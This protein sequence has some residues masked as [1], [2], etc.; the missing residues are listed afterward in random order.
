MRSLFVVIGM[1]A[2]LTAS[3]SVGAQ[4]PTHKPEG[5]H[6]REIQPGEFWQLRL[7]NEGVYYYHCH[8]HPFMQA[9]IE[10]SRSARDGGAT[11]TIKD[12]EF[13]PKR[14]EVRPNDTIQFVNKG[15]SVHT[16]DES[17]PPATTPGGGG[18]AAGVAPVLV[19]AAL[20]FVVVLRR[21]LG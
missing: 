11:V 10:V 13:T 14:I 8:P 18:D 17:V 6:S 21:R 19:L 15:A 7:G 12:F 1:L 4:T 3:L 2:L 20:V 5:F 16:V 9:E